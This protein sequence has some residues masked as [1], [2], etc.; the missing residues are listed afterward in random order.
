MLVLSRRPNEKIVLPGIQVIVHVVAVKPGVVRL[1][2]EAPAEVAVYREEVWKRVGQWGPAAVQPGEGV[3]ARCSNRTADS[4]GG[5]SGA[6]ADLAVLRRQL[7][8][9]HTE[10]LQERLD[11][12]E[13]ELKL[14]QRDA[15]VGAGNGS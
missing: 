13:R 9:G 6:L 3:A 15:A 4:H 7:R 14:H 5:L 8:A 1:G 12:I 11:H 2:V 10:G